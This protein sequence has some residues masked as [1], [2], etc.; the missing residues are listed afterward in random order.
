MTED[1]RHWQAPLTDEAKR[2][3]AGFEFGIKSSPQ[4]VIAT[5]KNG[6]AN[7]HVFNWYIDV[8]LKPFFQGPWNLKGSI[9]DWHAGQRRRLDGAA[10]FAP[11]RQGL[12]Y[13]E[14]GVLRL[15]A[16]TGPAERVYH[17]SFPAPGRADV[18]FGDGRP[19]HTLDLSYGRW[20]VAHR[21]RDDLF[22]GSFEVEGRD[23][24]TVVWRVSGPCKDHVLSGRYGRRRR[25]AG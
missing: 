13:R 20:T 2:T 17:Y 21:C 8:D 11:E 10:V 16:F 24:W 3:S 6:V 18:A 14:R 9:E 19:F 15:G 23:Y 4:V 25:A 12:V 7:F 22:R 1:V 5:D